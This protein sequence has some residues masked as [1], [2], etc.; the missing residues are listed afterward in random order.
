[1][2]GF[3]YF[4]DQQL[5]LL[6][7]GFKAYDYQNPHFRAK[8]SRIAHQCGGMMCHQQYLYARI[9]HPR[10][11]VLAGMHELSRRWLD[12]ECSQPCLDT[13]L[14]YRAQIKHL[15]GVDCNR[16][17]GDFQEGFY[18]LDYSPKAIKKL[19]TDTLPSD[20]EKWVRESSRFLSFHHWGIYILGENSD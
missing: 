18:P 17:Y 5:P 8:F 1:M 2:K 11:K 19:A 3:T 9:L 20:L 16:S 13:V 7:V 15:F 6:V 12:S 14:E 10:A 4:P